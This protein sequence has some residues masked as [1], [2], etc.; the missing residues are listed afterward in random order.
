MKKTICLILSAL[1]I[2][3]SAFASDWDDGYLQGYSDALKGLPNSVL[4]KTANEIERESDW[5]INHYV[6]DFGD[7]TDEMYITSK[8]NQFG[9]FSNSATSNSILKWLFLIDE[10]SIT[11]KLFEYGSAPAVGGSF[12]YNTHELSIKD[13]DG[14]IHTMSMNRGSDR[15][16][17]Q[18]IY[19]DEF[20]ELLKLEAPL[21]MVIK[22]TSKYSRTTYNLGTFDLHGFNEA[23]AELVGE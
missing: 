14:N 3:S 19:H 22:E 17:I 4:E 6:D 10:Y 16:Y 8:Y 11:I 20:L 18:N 21:K 7:P 1:L 12:D 5:R 9:T 13:P 23:Y 2:L 15:L